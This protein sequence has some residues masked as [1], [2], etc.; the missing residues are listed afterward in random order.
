V[1]RV[2]AILDAALGQRIRVFRLFG[3]AGDLGRCRGSVAQLQV[4]DQAI[5]ALRHGAAGV[6]LVAWASQI[7]QAI[8]KAVRDA[9]A[10]KHIKSLAAGKMG[11]GTREVGDLIAKLVSS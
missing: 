8:G 11:M 9:L 1:R 7:A 5:P 3:Q 6:V 2:G 4:I 10:S